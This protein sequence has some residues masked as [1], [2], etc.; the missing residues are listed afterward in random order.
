M[1]KIVI[2]GI[3]KLSIRP[4][5]VELTVTIDTFNENYSE[6]LSEHARKHGSVKN[7]MQSTGLRS[8]DVKTADYKV[9]T[10]YDQVKVGNGNTSTY[11]SK[12]KGYA[13]SQTLKIR[14]DFDNQRLNLAIQNLSDCIAKP[15]FDIDFTVKDQARVADLLLADAA[16]NARSRANIL[17]QAMGARL[18]QVVSIDYSW[19]SLHIYSESRIERDSNLIMSKADMDIEPENVD[20]S[21]H[22]TFV[23]EIE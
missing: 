19:N 12:F 8:E 11:I 2:T 7:A 17:T 3:G 4:D 9:R 20:V 10:V 6:L 5:L 14:F 16:Q 15:R 21:D 18:G 1:R 13:C 22:A 23:W